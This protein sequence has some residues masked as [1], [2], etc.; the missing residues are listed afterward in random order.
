MGLH[1]CRFAAVHAAAAA[2]ATH[3]SEEDVPAG[4]IRWAVE[5]RVRP[6]YIHDMT[7]TGLSQYRPSH[8]A[9]PAMLEFCYQTHLALHSAQLNLCDRV[10]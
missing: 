10:G 6:C 4:Q 7:V 2:G 5:W 3:G 1:P 9:R 8:L